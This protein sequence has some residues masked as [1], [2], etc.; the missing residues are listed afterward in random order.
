MRGMCR[1]ETEAG[2]ESCFDRPDKDH[3]L[4]LSDNLRY[5]Y[6]FF[7]PAPY[8]TEAGAGEEGRIISI[9]RRCTGGMSPVWELFL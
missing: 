7:S 1:L 5:E 3:G 8:T 9:L 4:D 2:L 6:R